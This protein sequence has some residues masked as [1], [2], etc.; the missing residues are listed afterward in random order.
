MY[1]FF[2]LG[3]DFIQNTFCQITEKWAIIELIEINHTFPHIGLNQ[4]GIANL[5]DSNIPGNKTEVWNRRM[6]ALY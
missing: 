6:Y 2:L 1:R 5:I 4:Y 3:K